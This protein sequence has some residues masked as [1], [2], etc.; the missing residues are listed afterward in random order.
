[1]K[2]RGKVTG[3][4]LQCT[5]PENVLTLK[6][7]T[8]RKIFGDRGGGGGEGCWS[9]K[10]FCSG[11]NVEFHQLGARVHKSSVCP[12]ARGWLSPAMHI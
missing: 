9:P 11:K 7:Y 4:H 2:N 1:M 3:Q 8:D 5:S 6:W 10:I 12:G